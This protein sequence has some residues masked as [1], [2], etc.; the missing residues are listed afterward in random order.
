M[1]RYAD[2]EREKSRNTGVC[3]MSEDSKK[4]CRVLIRGLKMIVKLLEDLI[5]E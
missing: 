1:V 3:W 2:S 5:K 4:I